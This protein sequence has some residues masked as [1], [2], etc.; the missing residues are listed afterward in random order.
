LD[1]RA[2]ASAIL[3]P[4]T[5]LVAML[6]RIGASRLLG[7]AIQRV[8]PEPLL[9]PPEWCDLLGG[10]ARIG[11]Q[12]SHQPDARRHQRVIPQPPDMALAEDRDDAH[13][14]LPHLGDAQLHGLG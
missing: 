10:L 5:A 8:G 1:L 14:V 3:L 9:P 7:K 4:P 12:Q 13:M 2:R 6:I 11:H